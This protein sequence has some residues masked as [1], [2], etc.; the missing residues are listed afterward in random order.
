MPPNFEPK[1]GLS[2]NDPSFLRLCSHRMPQPLEVWPLY[3]YPFDIGVPPPPV[4]K[5]VAKLLKIKTPFPSN[6]TKV[7]FKWN[8]GGRG[9]E[10]FLFYDWGQDWGQDH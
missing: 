5:P 10:M 8:V 1:F 2:P 6:N 9:E 4:V 3:P 7:N